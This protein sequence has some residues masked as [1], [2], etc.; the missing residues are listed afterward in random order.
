MNAKPDHSE[1]QQRLLETSLNQTSESLDAV[2]KRMELQGEAHQLEDKSGGPTLEDCEEEQRR[3][4]AAHNEI[5]ELRAESQRHQKVVSDEQASALSL[6][7]R[8]SRDQAARFDAL[9]KEL[10]TDRLEH[11]RKSREADEER[12][13]ALRR[14][15]EIASE[16]DQANRAGLES[17]MRLRR[18]QAE[19]QRA[20]AEYQKEIE[21]LR[22]QVQG[23]K[24]RRD[25]ERHV[26]SPP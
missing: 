12:R 20:I 10:E 16:R 6:Y 26:F 1:K 17:D 25:P 15:A 2:F 19:A 9:T 11:E 24:D 8:Q 4:D 13:E 22:R 21:G 5:K 7:E 14:C 23:Y 3:L 18:E